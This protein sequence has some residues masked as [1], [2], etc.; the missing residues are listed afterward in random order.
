[1]ASRQHSSPRQPFSDL[2]N[3]AFVTPNSP[4]RAKRRADDCDGV[5]KRIK[6]SDAETETKFEGG[7]SEVDI[8]MLDVDVVRPL[9]RRQRPGVYGALQALRMGNPGARRFLSFPTLKTLESFVSSNKADIF[10]CQSIDANSFLTP[11]YACAFSNASKRGQSLTLAVATEQGTVDILNTKKRQDWDPE[12]S[13]TTLQIHNNGI[14]DVKWSPSDARI[15]TASGDRTVAITDPNSSGGTALYSLNGGH[16]HTVKCVAWDPASNN[17]LVSGGRDGCI[18]LWDLRTSGAGNSEQGESDGRWKPVLSFPYAHEVVPGKAAKRG[19]TSLAPKSVTSIAYLPD[20]SHEI[21]SSGSSDGILRKWDLRNP[22]SSPRKRSKKPSP[23]L[24]IDSAAEDLTAVTYGEQPD[25][26]TS[27]PTRRARGIASLAFG[28]GPSAGR[29]FAL[30]NDSRIH[31]YNAS[32]AAGVPLGVPQAD[33]AYTHRHMATNS[34]YVRTA[35][36]PCGRWLASGGANGS[37]FLFDVGADRS[38]K[39]CM[40][41]VELRGQDGEVGGV[42]WADGALATC[43]DDGTVRIWRPDTERYRL[44]TDNPEEA[45][46]DWCW[47]RV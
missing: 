32:G 22:T 27:T 11:P 26:L 44:C 40:E 46:W 9:P 13:R 41:G 15:A 34:F 36:S 43:A 28:S 5:N 31:T 7:S 8:D 17:L 14:F 47:G 3:D 12:P 45:R 16:F 29:V 25:G 2:T 18:F 30:S 33:Q 4:S 39:L 19:R 24:P 10:K 1:M 23:V 35:V 20:S 37:A 42:D 21:V 6:C 38:D